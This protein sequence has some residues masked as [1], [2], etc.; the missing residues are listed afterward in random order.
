M[1]LKPFNASRS[2]VAALSLSFADALRVP[3]GTAEPVALLWTDA[4][5]QWKSLIPRL[6]SEFSNLYMLGSYDPSTRTGPVIWLKCVIE[7]VVQEVV[8][9]AGTVPILYLPGV[10]RQELR[11]GG[12]CKGEYQPLIELQYRGR[13]W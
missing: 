8:S 13:P 6:R 5:S 10:G 4:D 3:E 1:R 11:A 2:F 7:R 9:P 12:D